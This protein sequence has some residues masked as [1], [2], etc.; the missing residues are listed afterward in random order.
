LSGLDATALLAVSPDGQ[1]AVSAGARVY[2]V[3][4]D[5]AA[6][7][8]IELADSAQALAWSADDRLAVLHGSK[9]T[10]YR[11]GKAAYELPADSGASIAFAP[12]GRLA[13]LNG[14]SLRLYGADGSKLAES[15][16]ERNSG[17]IRFI[18]GGNVVLADA[19]NVW[20]V[21][22]VDGKTLWR[23]RYEGA[24]G[25]SQ[26]VVS[27]DGTRIAVFTAASSTPALWVLDQT[28]AQ[29]HA[30]LLQT[31]PDAA[32]FAGNT[33]LQFAIGGTLQLHPVTP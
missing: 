13:A 25:L 33:Q 18:D 29:L 22:P 6:K 19:N 11:S 32:V 16:V 2:L 1:S 15:S 14:S 24:E 10:V 21:N 12:D 7:N 27:P 26:V 30:E 31:L 9:M 4:A 3:G 23:A 28:G 8:Q 17:S 5:G 20:A